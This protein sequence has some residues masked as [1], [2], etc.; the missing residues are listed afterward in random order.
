[1]DEKPQ[2]RP[3]RKGK[4]AKRVPCR[5]GRPCGSIHEQARTGGIPPGERLKIK[6]ILFIVE[7]E[8]FQL[9]SFL[10]LLLL[11]FSVVFRVEFDHKNRTQD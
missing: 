2:G 5:P 9:K 1:M 10:V 8:V 4:S 6:K 11:V 3:G 7:L